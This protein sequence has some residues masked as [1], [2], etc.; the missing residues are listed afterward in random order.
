MSGNTCG[1]EQPLILVNGAYSIE[2]A[3]DDAALDALRIFLSEQFGA[4]GYQLKVMCRH[5]GDRFE[6]AFGVQAIKNL[7]YSTREKSEGR[8]LRGFNP[9]D[10]D[11]VLLDYLDLYKEADLVVLGAGNFINDNSFGLFRGMLPRMAISAGLATLANTPC[12][13]YGL[14][15][16]RLESRL[17]IEM[18]QFLLNSVDCVTFRERESVDLLREQGLNLPNDFEILPDP[19]VI[20][21]SST[22][23]EVNTI[24]QK[25]GI[26]QEP[27]SKMLVVGV[28][29]LAYKGEEVDNYVFQQ[30]T[31]VI[32]RWINEGGD[33]LF[34]PQCTYGRDSPDSDDRNVASRVIKRLNHTEQ[35][36]EVSGKHWP[37][38]I[39]GMYSS[40]DAA[41]C[42]R[43]HAGVFAVKQGVPTVHLS[44]EPKVV[45]FWR[46]IGLEKYSLPL[47]TQGEKIYEALQNSISQFTNDDVR[48]HIGDLQQKSKRYG[49][50]AADLIQSN[51][52][53]TSRSDTTGGS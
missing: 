35:V 6:A 30:L 8:W 49:V 44:Y 42:I 25:E 4:D 27:G 51:S 3:G 43:L 20:S 10:E 11:G 2:S 36:Y 39:E 15:S 22:V 53:S 24:L 32:Q 29:S 9:D 7:E 47:M 21:S 34:I 38:E 16:S 48:N 52:S 1:F 19:V 41:L 13:L 40:A 46:Q 37:W 50:L 28:R 14:S 5:P 26:P 45:G 12:M 18:A 33:V 17:A 23:D 31:D